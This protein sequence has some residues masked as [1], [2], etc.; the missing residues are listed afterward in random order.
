MNGFVRTILGDLPADPARLGRCD[1]HEHVALAGDFIA[2]AF[3]DLLLDDARRA[4]EEIEAFRD[5]GGGWIVDSMPTG[6]GRAP[7]MLAEVAR[8]TGV[9]IVMP[10]GRHLAM[11][12]EPNDPL[13]AMNRDALVELFV[14]EIEVGVGGGFRCGVIKVA[15]GSGGLDDR[16]REAFAA[17][18]EAQRRTGCPI[19]THTEG[20]RGAIEQVRVLADHGA[21]LGRVV[22]SH[23]DKCD[24]VSLHRE[25][26]ESGVRLEYDQHFRALLRGKPCVSVDLIAR[27]LPEFPDGVVVG[28]DAAKPAYWR[29]HGGG[30]G[31]AWLVRELPA[32]LR[33]AG[34]SEDLIDR[35]YIRNPAAAFSFAAA[36]TPV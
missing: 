9:P 21:D 34:V 15:G 14:R 29:S 19:L 28:M 35:L 32:L 20:D 12:H 13:L 27:L 17:A 8:A 23:M 22:L 36:N 3:P 4:C 6:P 30:P 10:T 5:A 24:D 18:A 33:S 11:Y 31:L 7:A 26:L 2:R 16:E 1:A 25:L